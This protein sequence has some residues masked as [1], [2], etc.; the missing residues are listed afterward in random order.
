MGM[1][2]LSG[3]RKK[4]TPMQKIIRK[5]VGVFVVSAIVWCLYSVPYDVL[6]EERLRLFGEEHTSG[7]VL[8]VHADTNARNPDDRYLIEYKY[9]DPDG[10]AHTA[11]AALPFKVWQKFQAGSR[12]EVF[13]ALSKPAL[14]RVPGEIEPPFQKWLRET[15][16]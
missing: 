11:Y 12:I 8:S 7:L 13:Y 3:S 4:R 14:A 1:V 6:R 9:V 10:Y 5:V 2:Y 16:N 15:L